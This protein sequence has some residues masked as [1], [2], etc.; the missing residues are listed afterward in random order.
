MQLRHQKREIKFNVNDPEIEGKSWINL[1]ETKDLSNLVNPDE[2]VINSPSINIDY[3]YPLKSDFIF[4]EKAPNSQFFTRKDIAQ[5]VMNRYEN[6]YKE[7]EETSTQK[8]HAHS[9]LPY[10]R[11]ESDGKYGIYGHY[12]SD[13]ALHTL[14]YNPKTNLYTL[15]IDS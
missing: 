13:L 4:E 7:E 6:I 15:G 11:A 12:L 14:Y 5:V 9:N 1:D 10:N 8:P 3:N 2:N